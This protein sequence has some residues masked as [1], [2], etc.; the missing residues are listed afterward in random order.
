MPTATMNGTQRPS[1]K[2]TE[3]VFEKD[4]EE[5]RLEAFLFGDLVQTDLWDRTGN[6]MYSSESEDNNEDDQDQQEEEDTAAD[7]EVCYK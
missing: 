4:E 2:R 6:E 5:K 3:D 1:K 7:G